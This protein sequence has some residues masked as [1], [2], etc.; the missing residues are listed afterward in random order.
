MSFFFGASLLLSLLIGVLLTY[1]FLPSG[2]R[3][4]AGILLRLFAG[5]GLGIGVTSCS[6]FICLLAGLTRYVAVID[7]ALCLAF[8]LIAFMRCRKKDPGEQAGLP[9]RKPAARSRLKT[10]IASV[11]AV[12]LVAF[13]I[14][15]A[16]AFLKESHGRWDAWLIWNMHAR[17][18]FRG[19]DLWREAFASGLDWSHWDYPL[20]LPL[21]IARGWTYAGGESV[22]IPAAMGFVFTLLTLGLVLAALSFLR[23]RTQGYLAA[24]ILMG[25]PFFIAMGAA[26]FADV[27]FA[28][29]ALAAFVMLFW[30]ERSPEN[31]AGPLILAGIAAGLSAWT[32]NEGL[33]FALIVTVSLAGIAAHAGGWAKAFKR[34]GL[35]LAGALPVLLIVV[36]FKTRLA[37]TN[38]IMAGVGWAATWA[39]LLDWGR[40]A[41][42]AGAFFATGISF[43]QGVIDVRVGMTLNPGAVSILLLV[44]YLLLTGI[45]ID[46]KYRG[47]FFH[48]AAVL[49]LTL[50]G[51]FFVYVL[52]PLDLNW[53]LMTSLNRLFLQLWPSAV[54]LVFMAAGIPGATSPAGGKPEAASLKAKRTPVKRRTIRK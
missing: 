11:F 53:H 37:P 50:T 45:R 17:F 20:L 39:K 24:M 14:S 33:L 12:E 44:V 22:L 23:G 18:L 7:F 28:F 49:V 48:A 6:Y 19:G 10:L 29:F 9:P 5:G 15:F 25:T 52:T 32:K 40:Y 36:H 2:N 4:T 46:P 47:S 54:F 3:K 21:S 51:Y 8:G 27:P 31:H 35:F 43:T 38:D 41:E 42:I 1:I 30:V 13:V 26:Q 16:V 34:T